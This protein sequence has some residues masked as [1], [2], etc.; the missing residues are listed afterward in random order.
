MTV[1][2]SS[3][4]ADALIT[5]L[6]QDSTLQQLLPDGVYWEQAPPTARRFVAVSLVDENDRATFGQGRAIEEYLFYVRA[7]ALV[8]AGANT[9]AAAARIDAL[10]EDGTLTIDG[11]GF[12]TMYREQVQRATERDEIDPSIL[13]QHR[14][15]YYRVQ[16]T[17]GEGPPPPWI[18]GGWFQ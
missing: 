10:L 2:N 12:M 13:W 9:N 16:V 11:Y 18:Q 1:A 17:L 3:L 4:V 15:G 7:I 14:G 5:K 6:L 8:S